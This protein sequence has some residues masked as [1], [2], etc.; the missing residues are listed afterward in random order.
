M[1]ITNVSAPHAGVLYVQLQLC[2]ASWCSPSP[3]IRRLIVIPRPLFFCC[4]RA[5]C[6]VQALMVPHFKMLL[7]EAGTLPGNGTRR[8]VHRL[9]SP[10][11]GTDANA[12]A[13]M[14]E[15]LGLSKEKGFGQSTL[16]TDMLLL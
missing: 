9:A 15:V 5:F 11:R 3:A 2:A 13:S 16:S 10:K 14:R 1:A 6:M 7:F 12:D 8:A 4:L